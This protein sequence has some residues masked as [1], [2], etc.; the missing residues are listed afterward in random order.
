MRFIRFISYHL[1]SPFTVASMYPAMNNMADN[2]EVDYGKY[3]SL[4]LRGLNVKHR[5][6]SSILKYLKI[7]LFR[8]FEVL[9]NQTFSQF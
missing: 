9:Q 5:L 6:Q 1:P 7:E 8:N 3:S 4:L 2:R